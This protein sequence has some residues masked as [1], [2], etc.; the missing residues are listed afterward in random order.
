MGTK[1]LFTET[2]KFR[3]WWVWLMLTGVNG[4]LFFGIYKQV[5]LGEQFGDHPV[6]D[7]AL[8][9]SVVI[10]LLI[11]VLTYNFRLETKID[12]EGVHVRFFPFHRQFKSYRWDIITRSYIREYAAMSEYGGWGVRIGIHSRGSAFNVSGNKG[13]QLEFE[14]S[15]KLLIGTNK[16]AELLAALNDINN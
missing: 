7:N 5:I 4:I 16:P 8:M 2:Q 10:T 12:K 13:L 14:N 9:V 11:S 1:I 6:G 15:D 3:Q